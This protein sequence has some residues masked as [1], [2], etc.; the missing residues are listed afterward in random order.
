MPTDLHVITG[1]GL[2]SGRQNVAVVKETVRGMFT[3]FTGRALS[4]AH[5][6]NE[7]VL[8]L[9]AELL[10]D[11]LARWPSVRAQYIAS[12]PE[13][14]IRS[15]NVVRAARMHAVR[16]EAMAVPPLEVAD[17][18]DLG[19]D[20]SEA[21]AAA[22]AASAGEKTAVSVDELETL[23]DAIGIGAPP[24]RV[25]THQTLARARDVTSTP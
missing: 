5:G 23:V 18:V 13:P 20:D 10:D 2:H 8:V 11:V 17:A 21:A 14:M 19:A 12:A 6:K 1:R 24:P 4:Y 9:P 22:A 7:G 16:A 25:H 15:N 3:A